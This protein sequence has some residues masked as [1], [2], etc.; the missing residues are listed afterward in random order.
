[1]TAPPQSPAPADETI[2]MKFGGTS[3]KDAATIRRSA[4][5]ASTTAGAARVVVVV[6]AMDQVTEMLLELA[7]AAA[8]DNPAAVS[9]LLAAIRDKHVSTAADLGGNAPADTAET[10]DRLERLALGIAAV[11]ELT[12]RSRDAVVAFGETLSAPLMAAAM[13]SVPSAPSCAWFTGRH[14]GIVTNDHF[15]RAEPLMDLTLFQV[16][17]TLEPL[18]ARGDRAVVTGF[19]AATQHGVTTT[20]GRGGSDY[21]ASILGAALAAREVWIWSDVDGLMTADPRLAPSA[22]LLERITFAEAI[23]MGQFG[24]KSMHPLALEPAA[25]H[26]IP[27]RFRNTFNTDSPGT[28][29][30]P[31]TPAANTDADHPVRSIPLLKNAAMINI[32]GAA[33]V[34]R[35]GTAAQVFRAL[36]EAAVNVMMISQTVS[37]A[38]ISLVVSRDHAARAKAVLER[39]LMRTGSASA[40]RLLDDV[41]VVAVVG[42]G[43]AGHPGVAARVFSAVARKNINVIAI[44][45]GSSEL[46][47]S[48]VVRA[49]QAADAVRTLHEEFVG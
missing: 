5:I 9:T 4:S 18:L 39:T 13:S 12:P 15:G 27:V 36:G 25:E 24:A 10:L 22:R 21:T 43:M 32:S 11:G 2:V 49:D 38:G 23:E 26:I 33:M 47:I 7:E 29:I 28:L 17:H 42:A 6:S 8:G 35:P 3:M 34:G 46:S 1:M 44:A 19:I 48:F 40:V 37:E 14:A 16:R 31:E 41:N 30:V 20:L 45:Q